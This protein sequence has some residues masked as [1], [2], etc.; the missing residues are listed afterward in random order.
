MQAQVFTETTAPLVSHVLAGYHAC[1]LMFGASGSGKTHTL[2]GTES[3]YGEQRGIIER[4]TEMAFRDAEQLVRSGSVSKVSLFVSMLDVCGEQVRDLGTYANDVSSP[5]VRWT[6]SSIL[7]APAGQSST[8]EGRPGNGAAATPAAITS[9]VASAAVAPAPGSEIAPGSRLGQSAR[10]GGASTHRPSF[11]S[12]PPCNMTAE[13]PGSTAAVVQG[14]EYIQVWSAQDVMQL[15]HAAY[16]QR[17]GLAS[18]STNVISTAGPALPSTPLSHTILTLSVVQHRNAMPPVTSRLHL[19]DLAASNATSRASTPTSRAAAVAAASSIVALGDVLAW[20]ERSSKE[21]PDAKPILPDPSSAFPTSNFST[22]PDPSQNRNPRAAVG[23]GGSQMEVAASGPAF[24]GSM[25]TR[26]LQGALSSSSMTILLAHVSAEAD[27]AAESEVTLQFARR[28]TEHATGKPRS[29]QLSGLPPAAGQSPVDHTHSMQ[30]LSN[31][32]GA[33]KEELDCTHA[34]YQKMVE[35]I[36]GPGWL[37]S[38]GPVEGKPGH[39]KAHRATNEGRDPGAVAAFPTSDLSLS[40]PA[41]RATPVAGGGAGD[42]GQGKQAGALNSNIGADARQRV[43]DLALDSARAAVAS[44]EERLAG[45]KDAM[46]GLREKGHAREH[47]QF[48]EIKRLREQVA[49]L[50]TRLAATRIEGASKMDELRRRS[51]EEVGRLVKDNTSL[52]L[53][54]T[55]SASSITDLVSRSGAKLLEERQSQAADKVNADKKLLLQAERLAAERERQV[56]NLKEQGSHFLEQRKAEAVAL[57][58]ELATAKASGAEEA[59]AL[60]K[61][62]DYL[63]VYAE[64]ITELIRKMESGAFPVRERPGSGTRS[65]QIPARDRPAALDSARLPYLRSRV[66]LAERLLNLTSLTT[67]TTN[68]S[69]TINQNNNNNNASSSRG[70]SPTAGASHMFDAHGS[71]L[72]TRSAG[73]P[74]AG[75]GV[76]NL[77]GGG[78][79]SR[80]SGVVNDGGTSGWGSAEGSAWGARHGGGGEAGM[81]RAGGGTGPS[82]RPLSAGPAGGRSSPGVAAVWEEGDSEDASACEVSFGGGTAPAFGTV[83]ARQLEVM[84]LRWEEE[85]RMQVTAQVMQDMKSDATVEYIRQLETSVAR[86]RQETQLEKRRQAEMA[87]ALRAVQRAQSQPDSALQKVIAA[88]PLPRCTTWGYGHTERNTPPG[89]AAADGAR[90]MSARPATALGYFPTTR[91]VT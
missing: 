70:A 30:R 66:D 61:E 49:S 79:M 74:G 89:R 64:R 11:Y 50:T 63:S 32:I 51:E 18:T 38:L 45:R 13:Q 65:F 72:P 42:E 71:P 43:S 47:D 80:S 31:Q 15:L 85:H 41:S 86:Y 4:A 67:T 12:L 22:S 46:D 60:R 27:R 62:C 16:K 81:G 33:L 58:L 82:A 77:G 88:A 2:C 25:L 37:Q 17:G 48:Q 9:A 90:S 14:L 56:A 40:G 21:Q 83:T 55:S 3:A 24:V 26:L 23:S 84:R 69:T 7:L 8:G 5:S 91:V 20:L 73:V 78:R 53:Q 6:A 34:H 52:R 59:D 29:L 35:S 1:C 10:S 36:A 28:C 57:R 54:L 39:G 68:N 76:S 44:L 87:V 19:V 75:T